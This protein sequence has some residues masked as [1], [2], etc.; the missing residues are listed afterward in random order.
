MI[1]TEETV[2]EKVNELFMY[3]VG[4]CTVMIYAKQL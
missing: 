4:Y 3:N 2:L 1:V